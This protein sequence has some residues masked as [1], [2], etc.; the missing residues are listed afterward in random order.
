MQCI[1]DAAVDDGLRHNYS[2][3][4]SPLCCR[5]QAPAITTPPGMGSPTGLPPLTYLMASQS[6]QPLPEGYQLQE[7]T[8]DKVLSSGGFS[9]VYLAHDAAG[10]PY[11]IKEYL[12]AALV[13]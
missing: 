6:N 1:D 7:Y 3:R 4:L 10:T 9:I 12:P 8:I 2:L 11:A 13:G 5:R